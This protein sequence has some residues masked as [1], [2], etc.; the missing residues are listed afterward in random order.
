MSLPGGG[1]PLRSGHWYAAAKRPCLRGETRPRWY[2]QFAPTLAW[3]NALALG[4]RPQVNR[5]KAT[6]RT[7]G[8]RQGALLTP[9]HRAPPSQVICGVSRDS[10]A[11]GVHPDARQRPT[12]FQTSTA[13][14]PTSS[15]AYNPPLTP[16]DRLRGCAPRG[17]PGSTARLRSSTLSGRARTFADATPLSLACALG[18]EHTLK[19]RDGV[20]RRRS[21]TKC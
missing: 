18:Q 13:D 17:R 9:P 11:L 2:A 10:E 1:T 16:H 19:S 15:Q 7:A 8:W 12:P 21:E 3:L 20:S 5:H 6:C 4:P 14:P